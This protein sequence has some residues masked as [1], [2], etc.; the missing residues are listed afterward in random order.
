[1]PRARISTPT[2]RLHKQSGQAVSDYRCPVTGV[3]RQVSLG[4]WQ[5]PQSK[6]EH[7][8]LC[9]EVASGRTA[10][11]SAG[12][13][14]GELCLLFLTHAERHY[15]R[16]DGTPTDEVNNLK[17]TIKV[18]RDLYAHL[19]AAEFGPLAL[20][21]VRQRMIDKGW[22]R[23]NINLHVGRVSRIFKHAV[24]HEV[25]P[26]AVLFALKAVSGL[27]RGRTTAKET[28]PAVP[29]NAAHPLEHL[30]PPVSV[31]RGRLGGPHG[32]RGW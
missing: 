4:P 23:G 10:G 12:A 5:S 20:K 22:S 8:R 7:A 15:R 13:T 28:A 17:Q 6:Q 11:P 14:V 24:E 29:M 19:P 27:Q 9:A 2:Y 1:M 16:A 21:A 31:R 3:K 25:I 32:G 30:L 26:G 18:V